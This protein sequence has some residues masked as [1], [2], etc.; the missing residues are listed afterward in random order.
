VATL[1]RKLEQIARLKARQ[2]GGQHGLG[3]RAAAQE[4]DEHQLAKV[5]AQPEVELE[6]A[7]WR[8]RAELE[9]IRHTPM[10]DWSTAQLLE[11]LGTAEL[12]GHLARLE[13]ELRGKGIAGAE[14]V[15]MSA[16]DAK[17]LFPKATATALFEAR[18][19]A[20]EIQRALLPVAPP[21][22]VGE[23]LEAV[24][25]PPPQTLARTISLH[26][27]HRTPGFRTAGV[28]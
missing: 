23:A 5:A 16:K 25:R 7:E 21:P 14:L 18:D 27:E 26:T 3:A 11:W 28:G 22:V 13:S 24:C 17:K 8:R 19:K 20:L 4:L 2:A 10:A 6:L 9:Y 12:G 15:A 1:E